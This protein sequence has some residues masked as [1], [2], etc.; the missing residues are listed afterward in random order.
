MTDRGTPFFGSPVVNS[1]KQP[2]PTIGRSWAWVARS[3]RPA[4]APIHG[5]GR[6]ETPHL[7]H[8]PSIV[9]S[10]QVDHL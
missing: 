3:P 10:D 7:A 9:E 4:H 5:A 1:H 2:R 6:R 8:E